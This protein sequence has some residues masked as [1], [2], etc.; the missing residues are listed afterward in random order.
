MSLSTSSSRVFS[1]ARVMC[2]ASR[3]PMTEHQTFFF[4][5]SV[6]GCF[7]RLK[8]RNAVSKFLESKRARPS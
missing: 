7:W 5:L 1:F 3:E 2:A 4:Q 8:A 6:S